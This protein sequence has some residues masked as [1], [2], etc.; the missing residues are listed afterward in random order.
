MG[1]GKLATEAQSG[2]RLIGRPATRI[3]RPMSRGEAVGRTSLASK[4]KTAVNRLGELCTVTVM[5]GNGVGIGAASEFILPPLRNALWLDT[6]GETGAEHAGKFIAR[7]VDARAGALR[8]E[9][10]SEAA[11][12][13][14]LYHR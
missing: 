10:V 4:E 9:I 8:F 11:A 3:V 6:S 12:K 2:Q 5:S 1:P 14:D 7:E 13:V